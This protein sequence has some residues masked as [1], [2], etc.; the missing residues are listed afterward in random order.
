MELFRLSREKYN[1][2]LSGYGAAL[3]G[4]R[5][6]SIGVEMIYTA[7][8]RSL[9]MAEMAVH[10]TLSTL[11]KD[12]WMLTIEAPDDISSNE[13]NVCDLPY[14]WHT[15]PHPQSTQLLGDR[16]IHENKFCLLKIPSVVTKGDFNVLINPYHS[17]I[18]RIHIGQKEHFPFDNR[19][20]E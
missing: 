16:F 2:T 7:T 17:D 5:W 8:N 14:N 12:F 13:Q 1:G 19:I 18:K 6:N 15:Y 20:F 10:F 11:P 9:A 3:R 4:A